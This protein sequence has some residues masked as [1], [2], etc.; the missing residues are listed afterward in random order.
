M[1]ECPIEARNQTL[2]EF[3]E[4]SHWIQPWRAYL[5]TVQARRLRDAVGIQFNV[6]PSEAGANGSTP[7]G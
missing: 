5:D 2:L 7:G 1:L 3:G 4:R 6:F